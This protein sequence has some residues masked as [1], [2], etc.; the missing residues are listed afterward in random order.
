[1][2]LLFEKE[3]KKIIPDN[4]TM[5]IEEQI[6]QMAEE[7]GLEKGRLETEKEVKTRAALNML[8]EGLDISFI[9]KMLDVPNKFVL[10]IQKEMESR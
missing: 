2:N 1:M 10:A 7:K 6:L 4:T 8:S 9:C 3:A 5:G